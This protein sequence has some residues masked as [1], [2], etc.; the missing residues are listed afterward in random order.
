M[1][2]P[3]EGVDGNWRCLS[4]NNINL[5][6]RDR[7]NRCGMPKGSDGLAGMMGN[8]M[9]PPPPKKGAPIEGVDGNWRCGSCSNI[10]YAVR[11]KCNR[12]GGPRPSPTTAFMD[13]GGVFQLAGLSNGL[14]LNGLSAAYFSAQQSAQQQ[15]G[16]QRGPTTEVAQLQAQLALLT[17]R[18]TNLESQVQTLQNQLA[19]QAA[20]LSGAGIASPITSLNPLRQ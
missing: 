6:V 12:C 14:G 17:Q 18:Q 10:N 11:D 9:P 7:C 13:A 5:G 15:L 19:Q 2:A 3:I 8:A 1:P 20:L 4:C 16:S